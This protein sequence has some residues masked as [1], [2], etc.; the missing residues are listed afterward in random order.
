MPRPLIE[1][2]AG[3]P[4]GEPT[5]AA[6]TQGTPAPSFFHEWELD[7]EKKTFKTPEELNDYLRTGTMGHKKFVQGMQDLGSQRRAMDERDT[8]FAERERA[9]LESERRVSKYNQI[10]DAR[11]DLFDYVDKNAQNPSLSSGKHCRNSTTGRPWRS[12]S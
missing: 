8:K 12:K 1:P 5:V 11:P 6:P 3:A 7:G 4:L 2:S 9:V 10:F